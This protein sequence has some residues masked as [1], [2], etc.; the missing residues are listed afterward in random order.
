MELH[1]K[2]IEYATSTVS[3]SDVALQASVDDGETW[4]NVTVTEDGVAKILIAGPE[5]ESPPSNAV[6]I[7]SNVVLLVK[8]TDDPERPIRN[9]G[10][11]TLWG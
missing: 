8:A 3:R 10:T 11:I 7:S 4:H 2:A 9:W 6:V 1:K 5:A